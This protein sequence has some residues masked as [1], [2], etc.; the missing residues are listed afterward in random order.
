MGHPHDPEGHRHHN[1]VW[2]SHNDVN[3]I[4]FWADGGAGRIVHRQILRL[5]DGEEAAFVSR[6][7]WENG[8]GKV[9]VDEQRRV[10]VRG[11]PGGESLLTVDIEFRASHGEVTFGPTA[12]GLIGV[13]MAKTIGVRDGGGTIKNSG[14]GINEAGTFRLP[15]R[16]VDYSGPVKADCAEGIAL[17]D[18]P[19]NPGHP[20]AFHTRDDGWMGACLSK[21]TPVSIASGGTLRLR[22]ALYAH[23]GPCDPAKIETQWR[24]FAESAL[25]SLGKE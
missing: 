24:A 14:G 21:D 2:I 3:G 12:F 6:N 1:S 19:S 8:E 4:S 25:P 22:Y 9:I 7:A 5:E 23:G 10:A 11:M 16:W 15:A 17:M 13:R 18:H 20:T